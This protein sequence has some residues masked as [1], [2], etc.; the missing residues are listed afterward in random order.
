MQKK[1]KWTSPFFSFFL[2][3]VFPFFSLLFCFCV[4]LILLICFLVFHFLGIFRAIFKFKK[5][6]NKLH[7]L[8]NITFPK[9]ND[10]RCPRLPSLGFGSLCRICWNMPKWLH[11]HIRVAF[12]MKQILHQMCMAEVAGIIEQRHIRFA[13][14]AN[15]SALGMW[16]MET[17]FTLH[18]QPAK[19]QGN[20]AMHIEPIWAMSMS[21]QCH[22]TILV[23]TCP[24]HFPTSYAMSLCCMTRHLVP[25]LLLL[26]PLW[27]SLS[28]CF[29]AS[30]AD[31]SSIRVVPLAGLILSLLWRKVLLL[32]RWLARLR[33]LGFYAG[34]V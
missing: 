20:L 4:F 21:R 30:L 23:Y 32:V 8:V 25:W 7:G 1:C 13:V 15:H 24:I 3:F 2:L 18:Q 6:K 26:S 19:S 31:S 11:V 9:A 34:H 16:P 22:F 17:G 14:K 5:N 28:G 29:S 27:V 10:W 33:F 12:L